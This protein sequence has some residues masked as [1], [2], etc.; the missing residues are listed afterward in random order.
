MTSYDDKFNHFY[1]TISK[2]N[3]MYDIKNRLKNYL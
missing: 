1:E 2:T 3:I